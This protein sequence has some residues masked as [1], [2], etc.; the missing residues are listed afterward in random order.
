[1]ALSENAEELL[2]VVCD[3]GEIKSM[4]IAIESSVKS[5][6]I[7]GTV[8]TIC[9]L[10]MGPWGLAFGGTVAGATTAYRMNGKFRS[11]PD[12]LLNELSKVQ[13]VRLAMAVKSLLTQQNILTVADFALKVATYDSV[14]GLVIPIVK[15]FLE[16]DVRATV[17]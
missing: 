3:I 10:L 5:G 4:R 9:G 16:T 12:V 14:I 7:V 11:V 17:M 2:R 8:T 1:M 15:S 13:K 6:I